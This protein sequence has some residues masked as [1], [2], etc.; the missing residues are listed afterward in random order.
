MSNLQII[1]L[2]FL[3]FLAAEVHSITF[4]VLQLKL[5]LDY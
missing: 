3:E 4:S 2:L 1:S 5:K